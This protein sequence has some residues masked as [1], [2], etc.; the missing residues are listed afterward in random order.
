M[1]QESGMLEMSND[2][3]YQEIWPCQCKCMW[4]EDSG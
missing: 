3:V 2:T 1:L 4:N